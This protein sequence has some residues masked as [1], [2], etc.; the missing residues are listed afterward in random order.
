MNASTSATSGSITIT[1]TSGSLTHALQIPVTVSVVAPSF[2]LTVASLAVSIPSGGVITDNLTVAGVGGFNSDVALTCSVPG[3]LGTTTCTITPS[4]VTGGNGSALVTLK[5][6]VLGRDLGAPLPFQHRS[7]GI[8]ASYVFS[9]GFVFLGAPN[10][11]RR[12]K[13]AGLTWVGVVKKALFTLLALGILLGALSCG[14]GSGGGGGGGGG[15]V[16]ITGNVTITGTGGG[17]TPQTATI[18]VTVN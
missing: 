1:A 7:L 2:T 16:P 13:R 4:T 17:V 5:G 11:Y 8:Y 14:G 3:S 9:L 6:A 12:R 15:V 10:A 18:N